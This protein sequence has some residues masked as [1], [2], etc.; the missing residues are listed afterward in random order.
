MWREQFGHVLIEAMACG[1]PVIGST[2][3]QI[4]NVIDDAGL[5]FEQKNIENLTNC[6]KKLM[7]NQDL[8]KGLGQKGYERFKKNYSNY[9]KPLSN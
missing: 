9:H 8:R 7:K 5:I 6:L 2:G 1:V 3:G 4:P